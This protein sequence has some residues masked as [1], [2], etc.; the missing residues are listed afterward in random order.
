MKKVVVI[1]FFL[2]LP[3]TGRGKE[4]Y[5]FIGVDFAPI[6]S[7]SHTYNQ[8]HDFDLGGGIS[9]GYQTKWIEIYLDLLFSGGFGG[10]INGASYST[11]GVFADFNICATPMGN[12]EKLALHIGGGAGVAHFSSDMGDFSKTSFGVQGIVGA[13]QKLRIGRAGVNIEL[14]YTGI[15]FPPGEEN[16]LFSIFRFYWQFTF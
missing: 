1:V 4:G 11:R 16:L 12:I 14:K 5:I 13:S 6:L 2:C 10:D 8:T 3:L 15:E 9:G 7:I